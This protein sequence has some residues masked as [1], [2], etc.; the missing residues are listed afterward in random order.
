M[1]YYTVT[2]TKWQLNFHHESAVFLVTPVILPPPAE[3]HPALQ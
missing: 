3:D 2:Q 1:L